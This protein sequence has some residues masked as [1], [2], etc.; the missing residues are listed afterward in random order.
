MAQ[1]P[2]EPKIGDTMPDGT[3]FAGITCANR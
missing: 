1:K 3:V 2:T